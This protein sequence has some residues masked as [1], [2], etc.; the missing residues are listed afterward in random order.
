M[1]VLSVEIDESIRLYNDQKELVGEVGIVGIRGDKVRLGL[2]FN[3][4]I[5]IARPGVSVEQA[6]AI[7][8]SAEKRKDEFAKHGKT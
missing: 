2:I 1:L 6:M 4:G 5:H 7:N 3:K 8:N